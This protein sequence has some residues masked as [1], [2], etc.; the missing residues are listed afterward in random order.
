MERRE[1]GGRV[2]VHLLQ[3]EDTMRRKDKR[4]QVSLRCSVATDHK[5]YDEE[6]TLREGS[7]DEE[8]TSKVCPLVGVGGSMWESEK[9]IS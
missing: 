4:E 9:I 3:V 8:E 6:R 2:L 5:K 7:V 1:Q